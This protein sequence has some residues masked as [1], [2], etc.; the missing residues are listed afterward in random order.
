MT[1]SATISSPFTSLRD[2][3][4]GSYNGD[5]FYVNIMAYLRAPSAKALKK[6]T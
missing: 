6:L 5:P 1:I 3:I 2:Q 4:I